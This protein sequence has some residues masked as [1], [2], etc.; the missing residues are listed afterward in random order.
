MS[1]QPIS[2]GRSCNCGTLWGSIYPKPPCPVHAPQPDP[3]PVVIREHCHCCG[4]VHEYR[5]NDLRVTL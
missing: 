5:R 3:N 1:T 4:K 2:L